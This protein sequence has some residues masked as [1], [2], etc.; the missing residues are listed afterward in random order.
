MANIDCCGITQLLRGLIAQSQITE[1]EA[2]KILT[3][4]TN[5]TGADIVISF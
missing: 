4:I 1:R 2:R 3:R 5:Q